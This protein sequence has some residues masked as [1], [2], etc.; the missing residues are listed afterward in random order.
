MSAV[1]CS[2]NFAVAARATVAPRA[3]ARRNAAPAKK[4]VAQPKP[5]VF[6]ASVAGAAAA[7]APLAAHAQEVAQVADGVGLAV[8]GAAAI[9]GIAGVLVATDPSKR[10]ENMMS[11]TGGDEAASVRNYFDT[12]VGRC[13]LDPSSKAALLFKT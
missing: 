4:N 8:G 1:S 2:A 10:R 7:A 3:S 9:A 6:T 5:A 12:E 13:K 11:E